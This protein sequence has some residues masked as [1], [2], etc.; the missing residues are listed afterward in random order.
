M[1]F[2]FCAVTVNKWFM[3]FKEISSN[4]FKENL[5][6]LGGLDENKEP[7]V[8]EIDESYFFHRKYHRVVYYRN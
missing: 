6:E 5:K 1:N 2:R 8:V 3:Y 7:S 4:Y